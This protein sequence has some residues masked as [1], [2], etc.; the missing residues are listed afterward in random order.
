MSRTR[1]EASQNDFA[2]LMVGELEPP[3]WRQ[4]LANK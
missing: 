2:R 4:C 1:H 3:P